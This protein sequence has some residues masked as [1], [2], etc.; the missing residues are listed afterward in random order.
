MNRDRITRRH[1]GRDS[2]GLTDSGPVKKS[3]PVPGQKISQSALAPDLPISTSYVRRK[4]DRT[5]STSFNQKSTG[6]Q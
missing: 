2:D 3:S 5:H 4:N 1:M 6:T